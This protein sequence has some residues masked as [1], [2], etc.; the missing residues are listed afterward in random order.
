MAFYLQNRRIWIDA[1]KNKSLDNLS[2]DYIGELCARDE[3]GEIDISKYFKV[4]DTKTIHINEI[5]GNPGTWYND[6]Y[7][8]QDLIYR[9][10]GIHHDIMTN[11]NKAALTFMATRSDYIYQYWDN[12]KAESGHYDSTNDMYTYKASLYTESTIHKFLTNYYIKAYPNDLQKYIKTVKKIT[13]QGASSNTTPV[14]T[15][16]TSYQYSQ[17]VTTNEQIFILSADELLGAIDSMYSWQI[18]DSPQYQYF[19][20]NSPD[21][22]LK[23]QTMSL[24]SSWFDVTKNALSDYAYHYVMEDR[25]T[26]LLTQGIGGW[27]NF[28]PAFSM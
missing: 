28:A 24:R 13:A 20:E 27:D 3:A 22:A 21:D 15:D 16:R 1:N 18:T 6:T 2:W 23:R 25:N 4:G 7:D 9:I 12:P 17:Q 10:I 5:T 14:R 8:A 19:I 11:G 26:N